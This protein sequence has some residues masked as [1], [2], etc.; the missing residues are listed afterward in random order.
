MDYTPA[1]AAAVVSATV[2][3]ILELA[4]RRYF[5][6]YL[7]EHPREPAERPWLSWGEGLDSMT[8]GPWD[9]LPAWRVLRRPVTPQLLARQR[10]AL[11]AFMLVPAFLILAFALIGTRDRL[12]AFGLALGLATELTL[13]GWPS[14]FWISRESVDAGLGR[15]TG[16]TLRLALAVPVFLIFGLILVLPRVIATR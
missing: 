7:D 12:L 6:A 10:A 4:Q 5:K 2:L 3:S 15:W 9:Y 13:F 11:L 8:F 14:A 16:L 1:L